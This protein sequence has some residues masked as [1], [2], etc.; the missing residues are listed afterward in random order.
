MYNKE[1]FLLPIWTKPLTVADGKDNEKD[2]MHV[3]RRP[4]GWYYLNV[5]KLVL[6][7]HIL[8]N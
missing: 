4:I 5:D 3:D 2:Q 1:N 7:V 6:S 8:A